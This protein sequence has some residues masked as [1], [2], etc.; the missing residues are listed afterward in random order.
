MASRSEW[1]ASHCLISPDSTASMRRW[2]LSKKSGSWG[3][4][5]IES[6][7]VFVFDVK[8]L[9]SP[10]SFSRIWT[11]CSA[12]C[13]AVWHSRV[14][15]MPFSKA[16][17]ESSRLSSPS[18]IELTSRSNSSSAS[19]KLNSGCCFEAIRV[20][21]TVL[22]WRFAFGKSTAADF[23]LVCSTCFDLPPR[24]PTLRAGHT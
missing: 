19:S 2:Q 8:S 22:W 1:L 14:S 9:V 12:F 15:L 6:A 13:S 11:F 7:L 24:P 16:V 18:S 4:E 17:M 20:A 21:M 10:L 23:K 5:S 3:G